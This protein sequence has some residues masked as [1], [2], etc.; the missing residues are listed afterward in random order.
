MGEIQNQSMKPS[1]VHKKSKRVT[2]DEQ[3]GWRGEQKH[4]IL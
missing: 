3:K 4:R 2:A 1:K